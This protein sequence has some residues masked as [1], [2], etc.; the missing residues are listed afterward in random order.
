MTLY[1]DLLVGPGA[2]LTWRTT[3][4][5]MQ[6]QDLI[7]W[8]NTAYPEKQWIK[9]QRLFKAAEEIAEWETRNRGWTRGVLRV[10]NRKAVA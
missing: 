9:A 2:V 3:G 4:R 7:D 6:P 8:F 1:D 10:R 5:R